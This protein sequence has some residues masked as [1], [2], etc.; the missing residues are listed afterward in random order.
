MIELLIIFLTQEFNKYFNWLST[1]GKF[2]NK[3]EEQ[4]MP[5]KSG[6][7]HLLTENQELLIRQIFTFFLNYIYIYIYYMIII[8]K[9]YFFKIINAYLER[10]LNES[11]GAEL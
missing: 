3:Q 9:K 6:T 8:D 5:V 4:L 10:N 7:S 11:N 1:S 2:S